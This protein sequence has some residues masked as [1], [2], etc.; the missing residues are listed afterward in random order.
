MACGAFCLAPLLGFPTSS[1]AAC[2]LT[3][4]AFPGNTGN[5]TFQYNLSTGFPGG[6]LF[7]D[8]VNVG[9]SA[10]PAG[11]Y[12]G[13]CIDVVDGINDQS[14]PET[15]NVLMYSSCTAAATL[16]SDL[17]AFG[18]PATDVDA[19]QADWDAVNYIINHQVGT[20][21]D[22]QN[23]LWTFVGGPPFASSAASVAA[24][25]PPFTPANVATMVAAAEA[26][27]TY[28]PGC[29]DLVAVI[30]A[31]PAGAPGDPAALT[32][33]TVLAV[34]YS[35]NS[36][37]GA[38]DAATIG[39][40]HNKNGQALINAVN[41]GPTSTDLANY[42][43]LTFPYLYGAHSLNDLTGKDNNDVA[44]LFL[45]F[46]G[47]TGQKTQAQ[48]LAGALAAYV[49]DSALAGTTAAKY[50]FNIT[51]GGTGA[52]TYNVGGNG[53]AIGLLNNTSY[54]ILQLLEQANLDMQNGTFNANAFNTIFSDIN[55]KGDIS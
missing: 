25:Y 48:I 34:P 54:T 50:G 1:F 13:W 26:N 55:Q 53:T 8:T 27:P 16:D 42:L 11:T 41:G 36:P 7:Q 18:Y 21:W 43:A 47:V 37:L 17:A 33:L 31:I 45:N 35:C 23:A 12:L 6:A 44:A 52:D 4:P 46:F 10:V 14:N 39:F 22:V 38:G 5:V 51:S 3:V 2:V 24:G 30:L 19:S 28:T 29:G 40:W 9:N 49:T 32:Q 20:F 15:Y